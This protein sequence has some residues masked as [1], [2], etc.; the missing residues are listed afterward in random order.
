M[1]H[2]D[3]YQ[4]LEDLIITMKIFASNCKYLIGNADCQNIK[5]NIK[6][7]TWFSIKTIDNIDFSLIPKKSNGC[8]IIAEYYEQGIFIL[9]LIH[10]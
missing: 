6:A 7:S 9:S 8:E 1:E 5:K 10:I 3:H 4:N 2:V